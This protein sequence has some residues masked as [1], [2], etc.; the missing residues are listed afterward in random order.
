VPT[1]LRRTASRLPVVL[2]AL[3]VLSLA[4]LLAW[5]VVPGRFPSGS[6]DV[7]G[8][9]P[10]FGIAVAYFAHQIVVRPTRL[11]WVRAAILVL[12]FVA[13][14]ANQY[15]PDAAFATG[16]NDVAIALFVVDIFLSLVQP[17]EREGDP[18]GPVV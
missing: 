4:P 12:A 6:H 18:A 8:A 3:A 7:L 1:S 13:W 10:L 2:G 17:P 16:W 15:W 9:G 14:A 5:D 11:G